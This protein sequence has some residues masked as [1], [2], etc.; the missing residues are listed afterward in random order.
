M[1]IDFEAQVPISEALQAVMVNAAE[2]A[3]SGPVCVHGQLE[4]SLLVTDDV[5]MARVNHMMRGVEQPTDV[6]SFPMLE[7]QVPWTGDITPA[8][9]EDIN[10][11]TGYV[12][13]GDIIVSLP[14]AEMQAREYGHSI[15][16]EL[17]FLTVHGTL[18]LLGYDH[19]NPM[20][21]EIMEMR[22]NEVMKAIGIEREGDVHG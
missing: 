20:D 19:E 10:P 9:D 6:L 4:L 17:A 3:L 12:F 7:Y 21:Q 16:R 2:A 8:T 18:H 5:E 14:R 15:E 11:E 22:Q 13:L 1:P